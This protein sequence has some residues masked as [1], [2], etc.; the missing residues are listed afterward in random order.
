VDALLRGESEI[1]GFSV[2]TRTLDRTVVEA[3][4]LG[5]VLVVVVVNF[6]RFETS[7]SSQIGFS[8]PKRQIYL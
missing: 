7:F 2:V 8:H 1:I 5:L 3:V 6:G 4:C